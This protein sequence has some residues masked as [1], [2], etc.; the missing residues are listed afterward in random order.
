MRQ[1]RKGETGSLLTFSNFGEENGDEISI[2]PISRVDNCPKDRSDEFYQASALGLGQDC[3]A[4]K[5]LHA[6]LA[7]NFPP[8]LLINEQYTAKVPS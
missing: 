2:Y 8:P 3:K 5:N 6:V 4:A 7:C 1:R